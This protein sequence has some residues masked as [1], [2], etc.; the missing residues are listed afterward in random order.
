MEESSLSPADRRVRGWV[1]VQTN[2]SLPGLVKIGFSTKE[3]AIRAVQLSGTGLPYPYVVEYDVLVHGPLEVEQAVHKHLKALG[4]HEAKEFFRVTVTVA[5]QTIRE[6]IETQGKKL[7]SENLADTTVDAAEVKSEVARPKSVGSPST[8]RHHDGASD[9]KRVLHDESFAS[10]VLPHKSELG[11]PD[12]ENLAIDE[13]PKQKYDGI[14]IC[15]RC[16]TTYSHR[17]YCVACQVR[18]VPSETIPP[19][20]A[21][22]YC[23]NCGRDSDGSSHC[24][25]CQAKLLKNPRRT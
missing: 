6:V 7:L 19:S 11:A 21:A 9:W 18:L 22:Y 23:P 3:P 2:Q 14:L 12:W 16:R 8:I 15:P 5:V 13:A 20:N 4:Q 17:E 24:R 1:Y 25:F 10:R